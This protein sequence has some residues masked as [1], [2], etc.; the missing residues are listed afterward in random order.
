MARDSLCG[1]CL[2]ARVGVDQALVVL[3]R[4]KRPVIRQPEIA[5]A[6]QMQAPIIRQPILLL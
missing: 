4:H 3:L 2:G 6:M 5:Q 1:H